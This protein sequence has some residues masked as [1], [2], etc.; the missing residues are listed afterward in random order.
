MDKYL[1]DTDTCIYLLKG[2]YGIKEKVQDVGI[3]NCYVSEITLIELSYGASKSEDFSKHIKEVKLVEELFD[4][5]PVYDAILL[6]GK[7]KARLQRKG[8]LIPDFDL[9]IGVS[10]VQKNMIL[11]T[12]NHKHMSRIEGIKIENWINK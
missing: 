5:I 2:K 9:L 4:L 1:I 8:E 6:F 3:E 11:V 12:G 10:A 7:E